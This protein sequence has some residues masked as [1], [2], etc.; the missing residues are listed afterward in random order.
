MT[1][2]VR[3][4]RNLL[5]AYRGT[6]VADLLAFHNLGTPHSRYAKPELLIGMCM[7]HRKLLRIPENFAYIMRA[8]GANFR[9]LEFQISFAIGVG[10]VR[11]IALIGHDQCGVVDLIGRRRQLVDG[12]VEGAGWERRLAE[13][14]FDEL[15]PRFE[16]ASAED[17]V[18]S[19]AHHLR[20]LY[21]KVLVAP[22]MYRL[23][24]GTLYQLDDRDNS[25][26]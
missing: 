22:L 6:A 26:R 5:P 11:A 4:Q 12:L 14:H 2:P 8:G 24:C 21:P 15:A 3:D 19:Q 7:G 17:S 23:E 10:G 16:I 13:Q 25:R 9:G 1:M 20:H 18:S